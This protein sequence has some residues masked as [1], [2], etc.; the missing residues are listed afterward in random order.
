MP[1][2]NTP[3]GP[4]A[5]TLAGMAALPASRAFVKTIRVK[6][7]SLATYSDDAPVALALDVATLAYGGAHADVWHLRGTLPA[8]GLEWTNFVRETM[9]SLFPVG[10]TI[11]HTPEEDG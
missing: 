8:S 7:P 6:C 10:A 3:T 9:V 4:A 11:T 5:A 2:L 1:D